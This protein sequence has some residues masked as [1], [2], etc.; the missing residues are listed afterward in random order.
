[1]TIRTLPGNAGAVLQAPALRRG[2]DPAQKSA[3]GRSSTRRKCRT[4]PPCGERPPCEAGRGAPKR[5]RRRFSETLRALDGPTSGCPPRLPLQARERRT[6]ADARNGTRRARRP[7]GRASAASAVSWP[8][9]T[10]AGASAG[11]AGSSA[12]VRTRMSRSREDAPMAGARR[13]AGTSAV[14]CP[15]GRSTASVVPGSYGRTA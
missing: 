15:P 11:T 13:A 2:P 6:A 3:R 8:G 4:R 5:R 10:A 9:S 1:M 14:P 7:S 12:A